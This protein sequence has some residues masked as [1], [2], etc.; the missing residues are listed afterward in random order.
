MEN[1]IKWLEDMEQAKG[2]ALENQNP[3]LLFFHN[4]G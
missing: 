2:K 3:I 4:P 1:S